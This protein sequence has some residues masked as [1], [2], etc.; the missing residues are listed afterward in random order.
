MATDCV[1]CKI[2]AGQIPC[3]R[4]FE[5][6]HIL[7]FLDIGPVAPGHC[8]IVPKKHYETLDQ[9]PES[10][11][12]LLAAVLQAVPKLARAVTAATGTT[13][14][15]LLQNNGRIAG[16][17][18]DHVHF[19]I[20]PRTPEDALGYRWPAAKLEPDQ[21]DQL[22]AAITKHLPATD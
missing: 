6:D 12:A 15:N 14:W 1:F 4:L 17:A 18:V 8:L 9:V 21:A 11:D 5:D 13:A 10:D 3:Y 16:Q 22:R 19:H 7:A 20:I 2:V